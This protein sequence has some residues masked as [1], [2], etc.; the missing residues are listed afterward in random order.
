VDLHLSLR[1][2]RGSTDSHPKFRFM[3]SR[4]NYLWSDIHRT[5]FVCH[6]NCDHEDRTPGRLSLVR[7]DS[8]N[9]NNLRIDNYSNAFSLL[10][11][12]RQLL[13]YTFRTNS[14]RDIYTPRQ[15][16]DGILK[17]NTII[18][19]PVLYG[20]SIFQSAYTCCTIIAGMDGIQLVCAFTNIFHDDY[21][22]AGIDY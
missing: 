1:Q 3:P 12:S 21:V 11:P 10:Y 2:K 6:D 15:S 20:S 14:Q 4:Q 7:N 18:S 19:M 16:G 22:Y 9:N 17:Q 5:C 8:T 13:A